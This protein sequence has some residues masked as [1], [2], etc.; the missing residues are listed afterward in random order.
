MLNFAVAATEPQSHS[1]TMHGCGASP[2][3]IK[4]VTYPLHKY[5]ERRVWRTKEII[6]LGGW[7][8][9]VFITEAGVIIRDAFPRDWADK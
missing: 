7:P 5:T 9:S 4:Q 6:T 8:C 2:I 3:Q 1:R